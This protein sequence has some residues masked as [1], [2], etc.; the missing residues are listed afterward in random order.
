MS[1]IVGLFFQLSLSTGALNFLLILSL[2]FLAAE[3]L[4]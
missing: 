1:F 4:G 2:E 3:S